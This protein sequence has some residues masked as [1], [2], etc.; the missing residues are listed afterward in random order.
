MSDIRC[1]APKENIKKRKKKWEK[2]IP[3]EHEHKVSLP[4]NKL[5]TFI[6]EAAQEN[7]LDH[8]IRAEIFRSI[9]I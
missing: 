9:A 7:I 1:F 6:A 2:T 4:E 5:N 3:V 8:A